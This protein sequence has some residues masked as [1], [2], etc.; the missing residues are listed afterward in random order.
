MHVRREIRRFFHPD[1]YPWGGVLMFHRIDAVEPGRLWYNEHL[2]V[3]PAFFEGFV[4][5]AR[6]KHFSFV[7]LDEL[8]EIVLRKKRVRRVVAVTLDDGYRDNYLNGL[9]LF[10]ALQVPFCIY[11]ATRFPEKSMIYWWYLIE[12]IILQNDKIVLNDGKE[13]PCHSKEEK[14]SAF[15]AIRQEILELPQ[16]NFNIELT[17]HLS[18]YQ[19]DL[20]AYNDTLPLTWEMIAHLKNEPLATIGCHTHSHISMSGCS[21]KEIVDD[22]ELAHR[23]MREKAGLDMYH[24][25][26]PF[27]DDVAVKKCHYEIVRKMGYHTI[28]TTTNGLLDSHAC[29]QQLPRIFVTERNAYDIINRLYSVC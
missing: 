19:I 17:N 13:Y 23:L 21:E 20:H 27:G 4:K 5:E 28:A 8:A 25:A 3:S 16:K 29:L 10:K 15:L 9:P 12:D 24:F 14:E 7:S 11:V 1:L 6:K 2:K 22:I 18:H 26:Y